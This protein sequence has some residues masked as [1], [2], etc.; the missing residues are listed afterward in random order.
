MKAR[1]PQWF[2][3]FFTALRTGMRQGEIFGL[4]W[5]DLDIVKQRVFVRRNF[6]HGQ[7]VTPKNGR[8][9]RI[10]MS[11]ELAEVL[12]ASRHLGGEL[13]FPRED[14]THLSGHC[15]RRPMDR[16]IRAT[17][18]PR[19]AFHDL[20]HS[21]ASQLVMAGV[22][23]RAVQEF[24]GHQTLQMTMRYSHLS[25]QATQSYIASLDSASASALD[26]G[27]PPV[28][29]PKSGRMGPVGE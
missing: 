1:E 11:P 2:A 7:V 27:F 9:R 14:G 16:V 20:R 6:T 26:T 13:V 25:P 17:G 12:R 4:T 15:V 23:I 18:L 22:P 5:D 29:G 21:F 28:V 3:L 8:H 19:I 24:L 10:P